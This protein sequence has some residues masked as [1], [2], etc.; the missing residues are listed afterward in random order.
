MLEI[1]PKISDFKFKFRYQKDADFQAL[2]EQ[3]IGHDLSESGFCW[4]ACTDMALSPFIP[5][6][7][8]LKLIIDSTKHKNLESGVFTS[9]GELNRLRL[10]DFVTV[11][12][13][14]LSMQ[15]LSATLNL[16][17]NQRLNDYHLELQK[18]RTVILGI[19]NN[20]SGHTMVME[21][22]YQDGGKYIYS[23]WDPAIQNPTEAILYFDNFQLYDHQ[24]HSDTKLF[25]FI[26]SVGDRE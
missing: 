18:G 20:N 22:V 13:E 12:N 11:I 14:N 4:A 7:I 21:K 10:N 3:G 15:K 8:R 19:G 24:L 16:I 25:P 5:E 17:E 23:V 6:N 9:K 2:I 26:I 1:E